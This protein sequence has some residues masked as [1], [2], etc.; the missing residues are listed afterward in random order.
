MKHDMLLELFSRA[1][2]LK[3]RYDATDDVYLLNCIADEMV[4]FLDDF[5]DLVLK[6][7]PKNMVMINRKACGI[8]EY[9]TSETEV[10]EDGEPDYDN[11]N[12]REYDHH[13][14]VEITN[15]DDVEAIKERVAKELDL[16]DKSFVDIYELA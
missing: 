3:E 12:W 6:E 7:K 1:E 9:L 4:D 2:S 14:F 13:M 8:G 5:M 11:C 10:C 15:Q 16:I